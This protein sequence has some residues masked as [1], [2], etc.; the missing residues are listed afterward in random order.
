MNITPDVLAI[1]PE[2]AILQALESTLGLVSR[3]APLAASCSML[4]ASA[5]NNSLSQPAALSRS[6]TYSAVS[7]GTRG[8][9]LKRRA[10][11]E[12]RERF[13]RIESLSSSSGRPTSTTDSRA[14]E[15]QL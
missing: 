1:S 11:R 4:M 7:S 2:M 14:L 3:R 10:M 15:S 8:E 9:M 5:V 13:R 6:R 12:Y